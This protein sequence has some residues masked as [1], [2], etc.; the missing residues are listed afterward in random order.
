MLALPEVF[1]PWI[2][3]PG[4]CAILSDFDGTLAAIQLDPAHS[5]PLPEAQDAL[6]RLAALVGSVAVISGRQVAFLEQALKIPEIS[7]FGLYGMETRTEGV[8]ALDPLVLP[9]V[10]SL[11]HAADRARRD[12]PGLLIENKTACL[13]IHYREDPSREADAVATGAEI[14][15]EFGLVALAGRMCVELRPP[16][17]IDKGTT[18]A[19]AIR[20]HRFALFAG[21]DVGD[22]AAFDALD[23]A[24]VSGN[25]DV[26]V[27]IAVRS[28]EVSD[29]LL[30][31]ADIV[32]GHPA[33]L[34]ALL[35]ALGDAIG[36]R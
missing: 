29:Q 10:T 5:R 13:S 32:V 19:L 14:A 36:N 1:A 23:A 31:R 22:L 11:G 30:A 6:R 17:A 25:L 12:L 27:K 28:E 33:E 34:A 21:D 16:V 35:V 4:Q 3:H 24:C 7:L 2:Q 18:T 8:I 26:G 20:G 15:R 9:F